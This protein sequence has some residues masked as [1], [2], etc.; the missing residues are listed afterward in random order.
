MSV[1]APTLSASQ[2]ISVG[3]TTSTCVLGKVIEKKK[4]EPPQNTR[5]VE[6][7]R[8]RIERLGRERPS[9]FKTLWAEIAF[10]LSILASQVMAVSVLESSSV[11]IDRE[12][13]TAPI[14]F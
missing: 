4:S 11:F 9:K 6:L 12:M 1:L 14:C 2:P 13:L 8:A 5:E 7:D 10:I 3:Q